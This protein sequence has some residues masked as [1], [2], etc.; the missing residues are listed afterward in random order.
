MRRKSKGG[1]RRRKQ[2]GGFCTIACRGKA[3]KRIKQ[4]KIVKKCSKGLLVKSY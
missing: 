1:N 2:K 3:E 4:M